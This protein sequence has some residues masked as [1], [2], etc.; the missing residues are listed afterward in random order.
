MTYSQININSLKNPEL[1]EILF[2]LDKA[3]KEFGIEF[4][5]IGARARD[6]WLDAKNIPPRR[7]TEDIDFAIMMNS[8]EEFENLRDFL[9]NTGKFIKSNS[10]PQRMYTSDKTFMIDL[11]PFGKVEKT[12]YVLFKDKEKTRISTL[13]LKEVFEK[14]IPILID[15]NFEILTASLPGI[16]V[17]K[18]IAWNDRPE[19]RSKDLADIAFIIQNYFDLQDEL[20]YE[21]YNRYFTDKFDVD[22]IAALALGSEIKEIIFLSEILSK[23]ILQILN[24][25]INLRVQSPLIQIIS[26]EMNL[27]VDKVIDYFQLILQGIND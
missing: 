7:F 15:I 3:M 9:V 25:H 23:T 18:L 10:F 19:V 24:K 27:E 21:K 4:Y 14:S 26:L 6:F 16:V 22:Q 11:L 20:I 1:H 2:T 5:L 12:Y 8:I 13:G 17:L